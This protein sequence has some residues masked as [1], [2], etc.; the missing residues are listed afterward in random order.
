MTRVPLSPEML[1]AVALRHAQAIARDHGLTLIHLLVGT[2]RS[3]AA[4]LGR[5]ALTWALHKGEGWTISCVAKTLGRSRWS[6]TKAWQRHAARLRS[7]RRP[8]RARAV[9]SQHTVTGA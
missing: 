8:A 5:D 9:P 3:H 1:E 2:N 7:A 6:T 4:Q